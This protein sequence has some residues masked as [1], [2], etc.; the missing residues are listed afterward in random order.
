MQAVTPLMN[1]FRKR[2]EG[3]QFLCVSYGDH[4]LC[5]HGVREGKDIPSGYDRG[6]PFPLFRG[7]PSRIILAN[8]PLRE[9]KDSMLHNSAEIAASGLSHNWKTFGGRLME[10]RRAG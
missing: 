1:A 9:L 5:I 3:I 8:L 6:R 7:G 4:V 10:I 2:A